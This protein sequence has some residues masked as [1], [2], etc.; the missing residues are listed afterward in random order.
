MGS[1]SM[2]HCLIIVPLGM[3]GAGYIPIDRSNRREALRSI[4]LAAARVRE[5]TSIVIFPEGTRTADGTL[6]SFKKGGF[7]LAIKS[8]RPIVP[9]SVSGTFAILPKKGF[10]MRPQTVLIYV[11][12]PIPTEDISLRDRDWLI[13]EIRRRIQ[14]KL[15][16]L[17]KGEPEPTSPD[18]S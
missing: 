18:I 1:N 11:G 2:G 5:G 3:K 8:K 10:R 15:P 9:V 16:P 13:S 4:D 12:D 14:E 6:Q 7:H 17:E